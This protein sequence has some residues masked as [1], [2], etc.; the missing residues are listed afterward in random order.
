[1]A[2]FQSTLSA[3]LQERVDRV[4]QHGYP[5]WR[6][7]A[8]DESRCGLLPIVRRRIT[9][10][11]VQPLLSSAYRFESLY[12][13]GAVEPLTGASFFLEL[14]L[15]NTQ[16]FQLF[17]DHFAATDPHSFH[18]LLLDNGAFHKAKALRFPTNVGV[19]FFPPYAPELNPIERLWRDLKDWLAQSPPTTLDALSTLLMTRL[20][21]YTTQAV[22]SLTG[23]AY[24]LAA[25]QTGNG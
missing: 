23:F 11:G 10:R 21:H 3:Q 24:L 4:Q 25:A 6:L 16:G 13:Y 20:T 8:Q 14:P 17:L 19:L 9:A 7:W 12:L 18:L 22:R 5:Q 2:Q 15:L 1:V